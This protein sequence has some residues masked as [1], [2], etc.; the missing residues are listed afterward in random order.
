MIKVVLPSSLRKTTSISSKIYCNMSNVCMKNK[1]QN[2]PHYH[3]YLAGMIAIIVKVNL[4]QVEVVLSSLLDLA[5]TYYQSIGPG[6]RA[7]RTPMNII[8]IKVYYF[9][10][11]K[12]ESNH[13]KF[14][15]YRSRS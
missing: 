12:N 15:P 2:L 7:R 8:N 3:Q 4:R 11:P 10:Q 13:K 6:F 14:A 1:R 5:L 9:S